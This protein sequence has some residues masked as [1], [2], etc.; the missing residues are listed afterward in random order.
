MRGLPQL[1]FKQNV[2][3]E[4]CQKREV[5]EA[6]HRRKDMFNIYETT[7]PDSYGLSWST[8]CHVRVKE[9]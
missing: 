2:M 4:V 1:E 3:C 9:E 7:A 6:S 5:K 8:K